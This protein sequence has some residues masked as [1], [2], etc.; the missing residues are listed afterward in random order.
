MITVDEAE[1]LIGATALDREDGRI[2]EIQQVFLDSGT[3]APTWV[4]VRVGLLGAEVLVPL[5][6]ADWDDHELRT[7]VSRS[8]ARSAPEVDLDEPLTVE[9]QELLLTHY[10]IPCVRRPR[11]DI[12]LSSFDCETLSYSVHEDDLEPA[13]AR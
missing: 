2:G 6:G 5:D 8:S 12:D 1:R 4:G 9:E 3:D 7:V 11:A 13:S 10:G